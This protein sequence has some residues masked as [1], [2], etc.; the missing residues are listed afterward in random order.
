MARGGVVAMR[1]RLGLSVLFAWPALLTIPSLI[2]PALAQ[3]PGSRS[4]ECAKERQAVADE[5]RKLA[6]LEI[7]LKAA[8][9]RAAKIGLEVLGRK[10]QFATA[11]ERDE[12]A[13]LDEQRRQLEPQ[14]ST[15]RE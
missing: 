12:L 10:S 14:I 4:A 8:V 6:T 2:E 1:W 7:Q 5:E 11:A 15:S 9:E 3:A 13:K